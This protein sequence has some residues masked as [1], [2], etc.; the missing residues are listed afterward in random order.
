MDNKKEEIINV[1]KELYEKE[2]FKDIT[3]KQI[4][5]KISLSRTSIYNYFETKEEI[6][7]AM[8]QKEYEKWTKELKN[9]LNNYTKLTKEKF[10]HLLAKTL[11][12]KKR[13]LKLLSINLYDMEENSRLENLVEFKVSYREAVETIKK[14]II[15]FFPEKNNSEVENFIYTFFPLMYGIYPYVKLTAKQKT[16]MKR[17][18][19]EFKNNTIY[20]IAYSGIIK[21]LN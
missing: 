15:K 12:S 4:G 19:I 8:F 3:I 14:C 2:N 18:N 13:L 6:F 7:L 20:D 10:A 21:L 9:I 16:A 17:A 1:C 11:S 5:E